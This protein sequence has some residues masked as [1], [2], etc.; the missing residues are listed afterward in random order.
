M[1]I[2]FIHLSP[3]ICPSLG[4]DYSKDFDKV[5]YDKIEVGTTQKKVDSILGKPLMIT[6]FNDRNDTIL[7]VYWYS[8][9]SSSFLM[10]EKIYIEFYQKKVVN[11]ISVLDG[12]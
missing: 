4:T 5:L 11:K 6:K 10:Y 3:R 12:D 9:S 7:D 2:L 1:V 8:K